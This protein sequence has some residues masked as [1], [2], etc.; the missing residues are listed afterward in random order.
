MVSVA[1][2]L[3][4]RIEAALERGRGAAGRRARSPSS[5]RACR[6]AAAVADVGR[7]D[8]AHGLPRARRARR[9]AARPR[10]R[11]RRCCT[12]AAW[13]GATVLL[14]VD[15]TA[16]GE[17][18][19]A[20]F[21][22]ANAQRAAD[23]HRGRRRRAHRGGAARAAR[24]ARPS[25]WSRSSACACA[26]A[27]AGALAR[28]RRRSRPP[29]ASG[30]AVWQKLMV[31]CGEQSRH[32]Q[33]PLYAELVRELRAAGA[34]G[35]HGAARHLGLPRR[36]RAPRRQLLAAAP[37][38]AGRHGDRRHARA[39]RPLVRRRRR[40]DRR[41]RAGHQR[42]GSRPARH[43]PGGRPR[44]AAAGRPRSTLSTW[45][46]STPTATPIITTA[47]LPTPTAAGSR[48]RWASSRRS[49]SWRSSPA[50]WPTRWPCSPTR[51]T[52]SPT[53]ARSP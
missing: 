45:R 20:R 32:A 44:R 42:A 37:A 8:Q 50:C 5:A 49:W 43:R 9:R 31:Y 30:L 6:D 27:T 39:H 3:R 24:A 52:C 38:R 26:S 23:G 14:G 53:R 7:G 1:V 29:T 15:G 18:Q 16:H 25:R 2:D 13:P 12:A 51:R 40:A 41:D 4:A 17:R 48:S 22:A 19:R 10:G 11:R 47:P 28:A 34:A 21:F 33:R 46:T 36:S 35:R